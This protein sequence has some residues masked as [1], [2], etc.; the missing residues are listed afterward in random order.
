MRL[1]P[2]RL[3]P[4]QTNLGCKGII[5]IETFAELC[6]IGQAA[7]VASIM[8]TDC[9]HYSTIAAE[10]AKTWESYAFTKEGSAPH[11]KMSFNDLSN[12]NITDGGSWSIKYNM[13]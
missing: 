10:Y 8:K 1:P 7:K 6:R 3:P 2:C 12:I 4:T 11:Y 13:L 5:A 9:G